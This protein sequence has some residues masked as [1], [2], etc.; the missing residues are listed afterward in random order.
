MRGETKQLK[1]KTGTADAHVA[2]RHAAWP[3]QKS[4]R[5]RRFKSERDYIWHDCSSSK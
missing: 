1:K 5:L 2:I 4:P 3:L